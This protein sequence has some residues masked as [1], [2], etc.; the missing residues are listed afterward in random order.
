[1]RAMSKFDLRVQ[2]STVEDE[3]DARAYVF[4][5]EVRQAAVILKPL[6]CTCERNFCEFHGGTQQ[7]TDFFATFAT[8]CD[9]MIPVAREAIIVASSRGAARFHPVKPA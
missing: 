2:W 7:G 9:A 4:A 3:K 5:K 1:M 8:C 6:D